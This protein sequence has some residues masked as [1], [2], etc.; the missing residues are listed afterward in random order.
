MTSLSLFTFMHWR[1]KWQPTPAF[2]PGESQGRRSLVG[3]RLWGRTESATT[4]ATWQQQQWLRFLRCPASSRGREPRLRFLRCP[5]S[6]VAASRGYASCGVQL[7]LVAVSR[8]YASC[9][10]WLPL[11]AVSRGDALW[12]RRASPRGGSSFSCR[13]SLSGSVVV[14]HGLSCPSARRLF[15]D[16]GSNLC[17]L[18]WQV[19]AYSPGHQG[20]PVLTL[21]TQ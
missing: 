21:E 18:R 10:V 19:D 1:R 14:V 7:P 9:G 3:C 5:A 17:V 4:E 8:G 16:R 11:V 13:A 2:L 12:P 15:L 6:L 20:G